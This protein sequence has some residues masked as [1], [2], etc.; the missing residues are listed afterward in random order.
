MESQKEKES[1][2]HF[3]RFF[4]RDLHH[5]SNPDK[6]FSQTPKGISEN[7]SSTTAL[8][9]CRE[10]QP[11]PHE[12]ELTIQS[13]DMDG[14]NRTKQTWQINT[15]LEKKLQAR[16]DPFID[17][18]LSFFTRFSNQRYIKTMKILE[19]EDLNGCVSCQM[20][21]P[22]EDRPTNMP[23]QR[24][25]Q[26]TQQVRLSQPGNQCMNPEYW[27]AHHLLMMEDRYLAHAVHVWRSCI[28]YQLLNLHRFSTPNR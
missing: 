13:L 8:N 1:E 16:F 10:C 26:V 23:E 22:W 19:L 7:W 20:V 21:T 17:F 4:W 18:H 15:K 24:H 5:L 12:E 6:P 14:L 9:K 3:L 2:S 28:I 25:R 11:P 27:A